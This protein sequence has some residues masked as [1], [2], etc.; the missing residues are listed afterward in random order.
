MPQSE[1]AQVP[2]A[3]DAA[4][5]GGSDESRIGQLV[6]RYR[7]TRRLGQGGMAEVF[8]AEDIRLGRSVA[9][10]MLRP[11]LATDP[12]STA[13]FSR[14]AQA[15][16]GLN[17]PAVVAVYDSGESAVDRMAIPYIVMELVSG[18]TLRDLLRQVGP[19]RP[20]QALF[21]VS[22][23]LDAL[24]Y[25]HRQGIV[26]RDIKPANV[27]VTETG[28]VK[29]MDFGIAR[30]L[31]GAQARMTQTGMVVGT[32]DYLSPEQALGK[33]VD[34]RSDLYSTG[35]LLYELLTLRPPFT[36][37]T[38]LSLIYQQVQDMPSPPSQVCEEAPPELDDLVMRALAKDPD[39][40]FQSAEEMRDHVRHHLTMLESQPRRHSTP[41]REQKRTAEATCQQRDVLARTQ[42]LPRE[43]SERSPLSSTIRLFRARRGAGDLSERV[44]A[45]AK[46][47]RVGI[48]ALLTVLTAMIIAAGVVLPM[49]EHQPG[50]GGRDTSRHPAGSH[51]DDRHPPGNSGVPPTPKSTTQPH[52]SSSELQTPT[53]PSSS[54]VTSD[55]TST[56][57]ASATQNVVPSNT[58]EA[59]V[60]NSPESESQAP[61]NHQ[62][63][64]ESETPSSSSSSVAPQSPSATDDEADPRP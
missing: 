60:S 46:D 22:G 62:S 57:R 24:A 1:H 16:A 9:L 20:R 38:P 12:V 47:S 56:P 55:R 45:G 11:E 36:G 44:S 7:L 29:V 48:L 2:S 52:R 63:T 26:H 35:C 31:C 25:S 19:P 18:Q 37:D 15:V 33:A 14:E 17:H 42:E 3:R 21:L 59:S 8:A 50:N 27:I 58:P 40:R 5:R 64:D 10:K 34:H 30:A 61:S 51:Q 4:S 39:V 32:P 54:S 53:S 49:A 13:R 41:L 23:V 43:Y 6:G 28:V